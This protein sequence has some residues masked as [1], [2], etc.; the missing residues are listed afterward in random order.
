MTGDTMR[1]HAPQWSKRCC[2]RLAMSSPVF[3][4]GEP[5]YLAIHNRRF[6]KVASLKSTVAKYATWGEVVRVTDWEDGRFITN[7]EPEAK[8][9]AKRDRV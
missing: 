8:G 4:N 5:A 3:L 2:E 1:Q 6:A 9:R 7:E